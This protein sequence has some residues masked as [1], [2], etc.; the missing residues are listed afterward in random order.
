[1]SARTERPTPRRLREAR[2]RGEVATSRDLTGAAALAAGL[3]A[4]VAGA[5]A[6]ARDL[7]AHLQLS[8]AQAAGGEYDPW[9]WLV[10]AIALFSRAALPVC[11]AAALGA[12]AAGALQTRGLF[13]VEALRPRLERLDP[14]KGFARLVSSERLAALALGALKAAALLAVAWRLLASDAALI[15]SSPRLGPAVLLRASATALLRWSSLLGGVLAA[16][17]AADLLLARRRHE[18]RLRMT[19]EEVLRERRDDEGDP[20]HRAERRRLHR[21]LAAAGPVRRAACLVVNPTH[22]AVALEHA[23]GSEEAPVVLAKASGEDAARLRAEA[24]RAGVPIVRDVAL[25]RALFRLAEVGDAIP[26]EL[27]DAAAAILVHLHAMPE[28]RT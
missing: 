18:R 5:G 22:L 20:R 15:A 25:A 24:R 12:A 11:G 16:F 17:G 13:T 23:R 2:R 19:R 1:M 10:R 14:A 4:L 21:A 28:E 6:T 8:L 27:Y 3:A 7:T 9:R 26:E